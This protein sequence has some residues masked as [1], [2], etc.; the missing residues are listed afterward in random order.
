MAFFLAFMEIILRQICW[1]M[2]EQD[3]TGAGNILKNLKSKIKRLTVCL[4]HVRSEGYSFTKK[5]CERLLR[6]SERK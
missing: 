4:R 6:A 1:Q 3:K 5:C 2:P